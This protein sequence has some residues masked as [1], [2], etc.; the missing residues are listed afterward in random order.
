M[1]ILPDTLLTNLFQV[2]GSGEPLDVRDVQPESSRAEVGTVPAAVDRISPFV[3]RSL[4][5]HNPKHDQPLPYDLQRFYRPRKNANGI[6]LQKIS[7]SVE[8]QKGFPLSDALGRRYNGLDGR[9]EPFITIGSSVSSRLEVSRNSNVLIHVILNFLLPQFFGYPSWSCQVCFRPAL[10]WSSILIVRSQFRAFDWHKPPQRILKSKLA[11]EIAKS[12]KKF[13]EENKHAEID[14][15]FADRRVG[16]GYI[17]LDR[18]LLVAFKQV[19]RSSWQ[20]E[21]AL[22]Y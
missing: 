8:G 2:E 9:D 17:D 12:V 18:L 5:P 3:Q 4:I 21:L 16:P 19:S 7:F 1:S 11:T 6:Q 15:I 14:V 10:A 22:R 20:P 13:I